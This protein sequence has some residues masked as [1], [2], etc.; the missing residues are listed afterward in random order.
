MRHTLEMRGHCFSLA[1]I[2]T[3]IFILLSGLRQYVYAV[4]AAE[5]VYYTRRDPRES[6]VPGMIL[7]GPKGVI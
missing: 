5:S 3:G 7:A 2:L 4:A 1:E 6:G